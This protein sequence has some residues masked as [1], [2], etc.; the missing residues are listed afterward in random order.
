VGSQFGSVGFNAEARRSGEKRERKTREKNEREKREGW[1]LG[2]DFSLERYLIS[3]FS[4]LL[5]ASALKSMSPK[6]YGLG[7]APL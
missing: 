5:R 4:P 3:R 1:I 2:E 7:G 6:E